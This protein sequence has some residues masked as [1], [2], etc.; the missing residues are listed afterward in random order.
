MQI[1]VQESRI[2]QVIVSDGCWTDPRTLAHHIWCT[3]A[4]NRLYE[5]SLNEDL[6]RLNNSPFRRVTLDLEPG[7]LDGTTDVI[8]DVH[9]VLPLRA[10]LGYEDTGVKNLKLE[11]INAGL[12]V[13]NPFRQDGMLSFQSTVDDDFH[14]LLAHSL[15]YS[16]DLD[17][18][19]SWDAY[20]SW[21]AVDPIIAVGANQNGESWQAGFA[22]NRKLIDDPYEQESVSL[23]FDFKSTNT[24]V[25][26]G[27]A[28]AFASSAE[29]VTLRLGYHHLRFFCNGDYFRVNNDLFVGPGPQ[30]SPGNT[31]VAFN[32]VRAGTSPDFV[33]D[34]LRVDFLRMMPNCWQLTGRFAGQVASERLLFSETLGFGGY[35]TIRGYDQRTLNGDAGW[36]ASLELGPQPFDGGTECHP[37]SLRF[38][39][40]VDAGDSYVLHPYAGEDQ[41]EFLISAGVG[42]RYSINDRLSVR[43]DYGHGFNNVSPARSSNT[44][45]IHLG[46]VA[47]FGPT[48]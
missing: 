28:L 31:Q 40:F 13:G 15:F 1:V 10:Y 41:Q 35:D 44:D 6:R 29:L 9:D 47:F 32:T 22:L 34:R 37:S 27:G 7:D 25:E 24:N 26:F 45:R 19:W 30:F 14:R 2:G 17:H 12:V 42:M 39:G 43:L 48:P 23:G 36:L 46:V 11:R 3:Q 8:F 20:G 4:G 16:V 33:Y 5:W 18:R 21:A 38:F